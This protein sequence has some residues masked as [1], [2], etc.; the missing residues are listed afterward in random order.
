MVDYRKKLKISDLATEANDGLGVKVAVIDTG[1]PVTYG[2]PVN[3]AENFTSDDAADTGHATFVGSILFGVS[4]YMIGICPKAT[5]CFCKVFNRG[6]ATPEAVAKAISYAADIWKVDIINLSLGFSG[7][8]CNKLLQQA[9][10]TAIE[11]GV[12]IIA[13]AG[14]NGRRTFWP[15]ALKDVMCV[16]SSD[17]KIREKF[18]N[19]GKV[20]IVAPG[21]LL[22]GLNI[23]G[24]LES[25]TG[26][27]FSAALITGLTALILARRRKCDA[28]IK[29]IDIKQELIDMCVDLGVAGYDSET[30][31]GFPFSKIIHNTFI[32][33]A[34]LWLHSFCAIIKNTIRRIITSLKTR[35]LKNY[36]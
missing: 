18:S 27:S 2:V 26:T 14:N 13:A 3:L 24:A 19:H 6:V 21:T 33:K 28:A 4:K 7:D 9:C 11:K 17:G 31:Y 36:E 5:S 34:G 25:K 29:A 30:G 10:D 22:A 20:D 23:A 32:T 15:A 35:R 12:L 1:I 16:G 8:S